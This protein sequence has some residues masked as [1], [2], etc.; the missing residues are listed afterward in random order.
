MHACSHLSPQAMHV[1]LHCFTGGGVIDIGH[2]YPKIRNL[3]RHCAAG[4]CSSPPVAS[5][6]NRCLRVSN[7]M[8]VVHGSSCGGRLRHH[9]QGT[10]NLYRREQPSC[11]YQ[12]RGNGGLPDS[13]SWLSRFW[14]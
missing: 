14:I 5:V 8:F 7:S 10:R 9:E 2:S 6:S 13:T 4:T 1:L 3:Q 12:V 11:R